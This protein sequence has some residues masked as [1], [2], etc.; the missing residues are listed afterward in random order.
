MT[1]IHSKIN[2]RS[3]EFQKNAAAMQAVVDDLNSKVQQIKLGG[4]ESLIASL[5]APGSTASQAMP[6]ARAGMRLSSAS[7]GRKRVAV[8]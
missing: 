3:E 8:T 4:G 2:P 6:I 5:S 7:P 1:K